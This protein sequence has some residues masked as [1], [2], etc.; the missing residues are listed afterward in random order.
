[1]CVCMYV[2]VCGCVFLAPVYVRVFFYV[3]VFVWRLS[4]FIWRDVAAGLLCMYVCLCVFV[5]VFFMFVCLHVGIGS[6]EGLWQ[7][8]CAHILP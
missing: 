1:V 6:F 3:C 8:S 5:N 7:G 4:M 2:C